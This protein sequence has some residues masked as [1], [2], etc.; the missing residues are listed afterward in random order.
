MEDSPLKDPNPEAL[1]GEPPSPLPGGTG[2]PL[3]LLQEA[4]QTLL[5]ALVVFALVRLVVQNYR[6]QG[7]CM[8]PSLL[9]GQFLIVN[10]LAYRTGHIQRGDIIVF[11]H[12]TAP[13]RDLIKRVIGL[14]GE[15]LQIVRG[16]VW[17]NGE[18]IEEPYVRAPGVYSQAAIT[19][20]ADHVFVMGDNRDNSND[21]RR[22][23]PVPT[24]NIVGQAVF[25]YWPPSRWGPVARESDSAT[26]DA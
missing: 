1:G 7:P 14:P 4:L 12:P 11:E 6:I 9:E 8:Q 18:P 5:L 19:I 17:I 3:A 20:P 25:C 15:Q 24:Q 23:G 16:Q 13:Q 2:K 26:T 21:S 10:R 22:W